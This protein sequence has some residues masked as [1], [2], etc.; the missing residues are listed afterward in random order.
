[1]RFTLLSLFF[2]PVHTLCIV[3]PPRP[4]T[5]PPRTKLFDGDDNDDWSINVVDLKSMNLM[6]RSWHQIYVKQN[7]PREILHTLTWKPSSTTAQVCFGL[8]QRNVIRS[9]LQVDWDG[10]QMLKMRGV[11]CAPDDKRSGTLLIESAFESGQFCVDWDQLL[12][13]FSA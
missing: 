4:P 9:L 5:I 1:M 13:A 12:T 2:L 6:I 7:K 10:A 3:S 11:A 8:T